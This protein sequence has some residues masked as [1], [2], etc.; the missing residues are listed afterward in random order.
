MLKVAWILRD[1]NRVVKSFKYFIKE[2]SE[3]ENQDEIISSDYIST[4]V[5][6]FWRTQKYV[7]FVFCVIPYTLLFISTVFFFTICM[8]HESTLD[9][10]IE[11]TSEVWRLIM[12]SVIIVGSLYFSYFEFQQI[13]AKKC[14]YFIEPQNIIELVSTVLNVHIVCINL[15]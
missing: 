3:S 13:G 6:E 10:G 11:A 9:I 12:Q 14:A 7:L 1:R 4:I 2:L 5:E 15:T 8:R